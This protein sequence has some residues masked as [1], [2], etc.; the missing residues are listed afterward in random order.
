MFSG[1][2][3]KQ[4]QV[5]A[6]KASETKSSDTKEA[7]PNVLGKSVSEARSQLSGFKSVTEEGFTGKEG[8]IW[9]SENWK[10]CTQSVKAGDKVNSESKI[11]L[12]YTEIDGSCKKFDGT[13]YAKK[14]DKHWKS[15]YFLK[16]TESTKWS[17]L[18]EGLTAR[19]IKKIT[20]KED[21]QI[22]V[23]F[24]DKAGSAYDVQAWA[25]GQL[26]IINAEKHLVD[27]IDVVLVDSKG[28]KSKGTPD[29][30]KTKKGLDIHSAQAKC[31]EK[32]DSLYPYGA[33]AH[34]I[35]GL[36]HEK[37]TA[38]QWSF[39]VDVTLEN[40]YGNKSKGHQLVCSVGGTESKPILKSFEM[41]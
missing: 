26:N 40:A 6:P 25:T 5:E 15:S 3:D 29:M 13:A 17:S 7:M 1:S 34:W 21:G 10:I 22:T 12:T 30:T 41:R 35:L 20:S 8:S 37:M 33:K 9:D 24:S 11:A 23:E 19:H 16:V 18:K 38:D 39:N 32:L 36:N 31:D 27:K 14:I 4:E 2:D 28:K